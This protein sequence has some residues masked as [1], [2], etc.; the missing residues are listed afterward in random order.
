MVSKKD[1]LL[2]GIV[3]FFLYIVVLYFLLFYGGGFSVIRMQAL[4]EA[5]NIEFYLINFLLILI[6]CILLLSSRHIYI[7][8]NPLFYTVVIILTLVIL[9]VNT[10]FVTKNFLAI[11]NVIFWGFYLLFLWKRRKAI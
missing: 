6:T 11:F 3:V 1:V 4:S 9:I 7:F 2:V 5:I 8:E 10:F